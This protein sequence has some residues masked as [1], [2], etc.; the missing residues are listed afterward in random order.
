MFEEDGSGVVHLDIHLSEPS[1]K[2]IPQNVIFSL[3]SSLLNLKHVL[4]TGLLCHVSFIVGTDSY[5]EVTFIQCI[6]GH[7]TLSPLNPLNPL[8]FSFSEKLLI[9]FSIT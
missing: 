7:S 8:N 4:I 1:G 9:I 5:F 3:L 6:V 2:L